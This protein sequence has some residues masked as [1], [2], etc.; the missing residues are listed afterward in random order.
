MNNFLKTALASVAALQEASQTRAAFVGP[1]MSH[2]RL[3]VEL[4]KIPASL[5]L[6]H[7]S[8]SSILLCASKH[9]RTDTLKVSQTI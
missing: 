6:Q 9:A 5:V 7:I 3:A 4:A 1:V 2:A 8:T